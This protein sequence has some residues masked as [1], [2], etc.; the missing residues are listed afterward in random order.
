[1]RFYGSSFIC[2]PTGEIVAQAPRHR[3][4]VVIGDLDFAVLAFWRTLFPLAE[5]RHPETYRPLIMS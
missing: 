3:P 5:Q 1:V 4:A 2:N